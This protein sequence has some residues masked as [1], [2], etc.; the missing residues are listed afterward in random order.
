MP[1]WQ[2]HEAAGYFVP[3]VR[4]QREKN[5]H[6]CSLL[7]IQFRTPSLETVPPPILCGSSLLSYLE[8]S[9]L[10]TEVYL[11]HSVKVTQ[12]VLAITASAGMAAFIFRWMRKG[13]RRGP[14]LGSPG[15]GATG[16]LEDKTSQRI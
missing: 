12:S 10:H 7:F 16:G 5:V 11:L 6:I 8:A 9:Y 13:R 1:W 2:G 3:A 14:S 4:R 15:K